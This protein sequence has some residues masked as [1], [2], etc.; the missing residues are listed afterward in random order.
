MNN[1]SFYKTLEAISFASRVH[2]K[3]YRLDKKTPYASHPFRVAFILR[4]IFGVTDERMIASAVLHDT[5]EDTTTDFDD[6]KRR[7]GP[8]IAQWVAFLSKD[9]RLEEGPREESYRAQ[10]LGAPE[11]VKIVKLA[12][13][14]DNLLDTSDEKFPETASKAE[15]HLTNL[16][17]GAS[18]VLAAHIGLVET[19]IKKRASEVRR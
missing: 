13:L 6:L 8:V 1:D 7:F 10:L 4:H 11:E 9:M 16:K 14:Y 5:I 18:A 19:L 3:Q 12:D 15:K 2:E 17:K